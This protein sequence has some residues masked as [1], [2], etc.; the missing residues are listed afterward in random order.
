[1]LVQSRTIEPARKRNWITT[2]HSLF[3]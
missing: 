1:M 3:P 2:Y